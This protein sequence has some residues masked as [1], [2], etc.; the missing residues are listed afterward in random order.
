MLYCWAKL[1]DQQLAK[2]QAFEAETKKKVLA[3]TEV[4]IEA[5]LLSK[6]EV[7][8]LQALEKELGKVLLVVK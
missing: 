1:S 6:V 8:K 5:E 3:L 4:P 2:I 7:T